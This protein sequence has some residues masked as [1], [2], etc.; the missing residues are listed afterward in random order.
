MSALVFMARN[1]GLRRTRDNSLKH[2]SRLRSF[3]HVMCP[4]WPQAIN[5]K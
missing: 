5:P 1:Q 2:A 4:T 3:E